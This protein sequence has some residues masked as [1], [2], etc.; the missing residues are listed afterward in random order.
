M[1]WYG[2]RVILEG[3]SW[4]QEKDLEE[5]FHDILDWIGSKEPSL[6]GREVYVTLKKRGEYG[7]KLHCYSCNAN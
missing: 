2:F 7:S 1:G 3:G 6:R 5:R 4:G